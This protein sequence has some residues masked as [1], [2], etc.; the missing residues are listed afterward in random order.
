MA[1]ASICSLADRGDLVGLDMR[2][3][4]QAVRG[5]HALNARD[6]VLEPVEQYGD[7]RRVEV[8]N[9][10]HDFHSMVH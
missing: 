2:T 6:I 1:P 3:V 4:A 5:N 8:F 9:S 10:C 7:R